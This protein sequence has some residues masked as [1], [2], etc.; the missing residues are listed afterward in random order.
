MNTNNFKK[1]ST[2]DT[3]PEASIF[4]EKENRA[5]YGIASSTHETLPEETDND[6]EEIGAEY[7]TAESASDTQQEA[8]MH[9]KIKKNAAKRSEFKTIS[10]H[11]HL[12]YA[13]SGINAE[14][15]MIF[16]RDFEIEIRTVFFQFFRVSIP[17]R[18]FNRI[19]SPFRKCLQ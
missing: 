4:D 10:L 13:V 3:Q 11:L 1:E 6:D 15:A 14:S 17:V 12:R 9:E 19:E 8:A 5:E 2:P 18:Q 16:L 7:E